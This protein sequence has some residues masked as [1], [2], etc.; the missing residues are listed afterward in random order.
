MSKFWLV[1]HACSDD[2]GMAPVN[3]PE[4]STTNTVEKPTN[5]SIKYLTLRQSVQL[6][7]DFLEKMPEA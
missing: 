4:R 7:P 1:V 6:I 5:L 3:K 2:L